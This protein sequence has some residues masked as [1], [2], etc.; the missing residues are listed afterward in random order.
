MSRKY[1]F[2]NKSGLYF[3]SFAVV[4]WMDIFIREEYCSIF[5]DAIKFYEKDRLELFSF[6][7]MSSHVHL[8]FRDKENEP[9]KLL[10]N[11]KRYSSRKIQ[12]A[13]EN[14]P[15][16][17]RKEWLIWMMERAAT[18]V[19]N[20]SK[21]MFWQ[22]HNQ[23]I[24][25]WSQSVILQKLSYIHQNPVTAG[26]VTEAESWKYSSAINYSGG[27]GVIDVLLLC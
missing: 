11:I 9:E 15:L 26:F 5:I 21:R 1:K 4:Y 25:L 16:E 17:S 20:V 27:K 6:C 14:N 23:P 22:H 2:H 19:S 18:K 24:E 12:E 10:G 7:I 3:V 13:I 8:I